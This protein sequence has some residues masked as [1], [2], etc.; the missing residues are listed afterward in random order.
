MKWPFISR[1]AY[2]LLINERDRMREQV[3]DLQDHVQRIT[4]RQEGMT[5]S[6]REA[7]RPIEAIPP[8]LEAIIMRFGSEQTRTDMRN[9]ARIS[10]HRDARAWSEITAELEE[11]LA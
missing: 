3:D 7:K 11:S 4:R 9:Q 5:E 6:P 8:E 2:D 10:R 1:T